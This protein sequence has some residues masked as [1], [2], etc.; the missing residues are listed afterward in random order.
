MNLFSV[1]KGNVESTYAGRSR[2][3]RNA[4]AIS[5]W[6]WKD[7]KIPYVIDKSDFGKTY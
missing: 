1:P 4:V 6:L 7:T 5:A 3:K 2:L